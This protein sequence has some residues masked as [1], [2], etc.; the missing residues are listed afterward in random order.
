MEVKITNHPG[1]VVQVFNVEGLGELHIPPLHVSLP[2]PG[3]STAPKAGSP[4][5]TG[6]PTAPK[7]GSPTPTGGPTAP[8]AG[9]VACP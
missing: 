2:P 4:T 8:K 3:G 9:S 1:G 5:P 7:A 6:G